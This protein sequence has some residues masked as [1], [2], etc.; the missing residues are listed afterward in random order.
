[1]TNI[2]PKSPN[3]AFTESKIIEPMPRFSSA[4]EA[5]TTPVIDQPSQQRDA[6]R[7]LSLDEITRRIESDMRLQPNTNTG[8]ASQRRWAQELQSV[9]EL[10]ENVTDNTLLPPQNSTIVRR[11]EGQ[12]SWTSYVDIQDTD[13]QGVGTP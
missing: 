3:Q 7:V 1:M 6:A 10:N 5:D 2:I 11:R 4:V 8:N 13:S 9:R 12:N